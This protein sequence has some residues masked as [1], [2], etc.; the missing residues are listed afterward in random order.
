MQGLSYD[1][2]V[3]LHSEVLKKTLVVSLSTRILMPNG[4]QPTTGYGHDGFKLAVAE[5]WRPALL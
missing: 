5:Q 4:L 3:S 2:T 1:R